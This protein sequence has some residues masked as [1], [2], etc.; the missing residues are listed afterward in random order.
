VS[1]L[2][3]NIFLLLYRWGVGL[4][5]LWNPKAKKWVEGR[6]NWR[7]NLETM[8][9]GD[10][11]P[12]V[13]MHCAS[14]GE[15]EQGRPVLEWIRRQYPQYR[16][17][18]TFFSP[19]G[20]EIRKNYAGADIV[21]YLPMDGLANARHFVEKLSPSL[22]I[23]VRYEFWYHYLQTLSKKQIPTVLIAGRF[24][25][26]QPFFTWWGRLHRH[27][28]SCF[29][30]LFV[31]DAQSM[32]LLKS[33]GMTRTTL[34]GD[35]RYDR[36]SE[37][38][39]R[40]ERIPLVEEFVGNHPVL[41]CGS[42]WP[43]DEEELDHFANTRQD[44]RFIIAPHEIEEPHLREIES[45]FKHTV[46]YSALAGRQSAQ[47]PEAATQ[48]H[49]SYG[50]GAA[51]AVSDLPAGGNAA[52]VLIIDNIGMLSR[53]Y[54]YG[55]IAYVGGGFGDDGLHNILEAAVYG[56][57]V[58][59]GP[60]YDRFPEASQLIEA[61]GGFAVNNAVELESL[62]N[63]LLTDE[64]A[65]KKASEAAGRFVANQRGATRIIQHYLEEKRLLTN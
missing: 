57:P 48:Q 29:E 25:R 32:E 54:K 20:Y 6:R 41:V 21:C 36:V 24:R 14:L 10:S 43:E 62:L 17:A 26:S 16:I 58:I 49:Q 40:F 50:P 23:W 63:K 34:A 8:I 12:L 39:S 2:L 42:T 7:E 15:F 3:Y 53:L 1:L 37:I 64:V 59:H 35:T 52:N 46:R 44:L 27:M 47:K 5:A 38:A 19:S 60:T 61:G 65:R 55:W 31:Q 13:W 22:V 11:R 33:I 28:L 56:I 45:L 18:L 30:H 51:P 4:A 9:P